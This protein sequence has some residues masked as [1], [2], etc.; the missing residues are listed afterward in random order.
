MTA[1]NPVCGKPSKQTEG[2]RRHGDGDY[3]TPAIVLTRGFPREACNCHIF[4]LKELN[5]PNC[6]FLG[7]VTGFKCLH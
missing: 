1:A 3:R 5:V 4:R 7:A 6:A 2:D